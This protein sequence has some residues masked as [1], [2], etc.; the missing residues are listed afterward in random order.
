MVRIQSKE[1]RK[2]LGMK[3]SKTIK[4]PNVIMKSMDFVLSNIKTSDLLY[5]FL[6][7]IVDIDL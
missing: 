5:A 4:K 3:L 6:I 7:W 1:I 2:N